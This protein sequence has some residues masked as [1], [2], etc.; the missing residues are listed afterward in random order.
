M[1]NQNEMKKIKLIVFLLLFATSYSFAQS[2][3]LK[4]KTSAQCEKCKATIEHQLN[5]EKGVKSAVLDVET[6]E[7][8]I[9]FNPNKTTPDKLRKS[10]S[11]AGYDADTIKADE[12]SYNK[13]HSCCKKE[14]H[15]HE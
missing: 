9:I 7:A 14:G 2:D 5:F 3:T 12:K 4:I 13:L 10:V 6:K 11:L 1:Q 8:T 15:S